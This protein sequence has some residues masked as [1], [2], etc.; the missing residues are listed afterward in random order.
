MYDS[1]CGNVVPRSGRYRQRNRIDGA[2]KPRPTV[3]KRIDVIAT[4][5]YETAL[6]QLLQAEWFSLAIDETTDIRDTAQL[7]VFVRFFNGQEFVDELLSL[8]PLEGRTSGEDV[9]KALKTFTDAQNI[10]MRKLVCIS[11]DGAPAMVGRENGLVAKVKNINPNVIAFHC[12]IHQ[13]VLCAKLN[14]AFS[15]LMS[16]MVKLINFLRCRSSL[17]HR[18]LQCFLTEVNALHDDLLLHN[19]IRW[20]SK[21]KALW[22]L[23]HEICHFLGELTLPAAERYLEIL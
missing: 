9:F 15:A 21:G 2:L 23:R 7:A 10:D 8:L 6:S 3:S 1:S 20:L 12:I 4:N 11:T 16:T 22:D 18:Q 17:C 19:N 14:E 13:T 5:L